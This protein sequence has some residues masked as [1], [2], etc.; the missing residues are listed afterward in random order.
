MSDASKG[1][2]FYFV[3]TGEKDFFGKPTFVC[4]NK[5]LYGD[6][7]FITVEDHESIVAELRAKIQKE[8]DAACEVALHTFDQGF[9]LIRLK[10]ENDILKSKVS[11]FESTLK[12][13]M[14]VRDA[15]IEKLKRVVDVLKIQRCRLLSE[16]FA[17][18]PL[19]AMNAE[20]ELDKE[21]EDIE[22]QGEGM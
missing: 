22:Q 14:R 16:K 2:R 21:L 13:T 8:S 7:W 11:Q 6:Y 17:G 18:F 10:A 9:E 20:S 15:E 4:D 3:P 12:E 1:K 5:S 19:N